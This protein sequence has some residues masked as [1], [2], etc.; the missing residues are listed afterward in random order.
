MTAMKKITQIAT[1]SSG[2]VFADAGIPNAAKHMLKAQVAV[3][4]M[5]E[6]R[7][8]H[9]S[10]MEAA[11]MMGIRQPDVSKILRGNFSGFGLERLLGLVQKLGRDVEIKI[12]RARR[13]NE[14]H[15]GRIVMHAQ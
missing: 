8:Q 12:P 15:E 6:I 10:Q 11:D 2:N 3:V 1:R 13:N 7:R 9:L 14:H 4:I 5:D